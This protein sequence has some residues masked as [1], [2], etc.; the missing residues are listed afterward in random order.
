LL[1]C[2]EFVTAIE[3]GPSPQSRPARTFEL[4]TYESY[5]ETTLQKKIGLFAKTLLGPKLPRLT[6]MVAYENMTGAG[7]RRGLRSVPI[8][9]GRSSR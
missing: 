5:T 1:R 7:K 4:R 3:T 6:Y 2:F 9:T 8:P